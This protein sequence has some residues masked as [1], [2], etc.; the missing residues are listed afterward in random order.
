MSY[1][2]VWQFHVKPGLEVEFERVYGPQGDWAKLFRKAAG[3]EG[4]ELLHD[5]AASHSYV[6]ID[7]WQSESAFAAFK[8]KFAEDY[9]RMDK[10]CERFTES[11]T[12]IGDFLNI[13]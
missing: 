11:E 2:R 3:Y 13:P 12:A 1:I 4:T 6:T 7:R 8:Q 5:I 9:R 10:A